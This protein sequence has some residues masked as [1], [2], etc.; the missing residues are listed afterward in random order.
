[1]SYATTPEP[2]PW[3]SG[4]KCRVILNE[5]DVG[6]RKALGI[7]ALRKIARM[8]VVLGAVAAAAVPLS[9][10]APAANVAFSASQDK[11]VLSREIHHQLQVLPFY[12]VFDYISFSLKGNVVVLTGYV[13]RA[14]LKTDAEQAVKSL[15]GVAGV[16]NQI[17]VLPASP[18][19]DELRRNIYRAVYEHPSLERYAVQTLPPIRIIVNRGNVILE[20]AVDSQGDKNLAAAKAGSV[21]GIH[22]VSNNLVVQ[23]RASAGQ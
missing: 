1:L 13:L 23:E 17:Q 21:N 19:D 16:Q 22:G 4:D 2:W 3:S 18:A 20:G 8:A 15:E 6:G 7:A 5:A 14:G 9:F 12:S 11:A 10:V